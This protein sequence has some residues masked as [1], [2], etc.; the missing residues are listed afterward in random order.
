[1]TQKVSI[2]IPTLNHSEFLIRQLRYYASVES[3]HPV[4]IGD[5]SD[6]EHRRSTELAIEKLQHQITIYYHHWP[7]LNDRQTIKRLGGVAGESYCAFT[8]DDDFLIPDSL[9]KCAG[10]LEGNPEY[11]TAQGKAVLF[12]LKEPDTFGALG[13]YW[14][15]KEAME[16]TGVDRILH[17]GKNYW[18]PQF[19][20]HRQDEFLE[21]SLNYGEISNRSFGEILHCFTFIC[22]GKSKFVDC[23]YMLRQGHDSR[24]KLPDSFDWLTSPDWQP[25]FRLFMNT[26]SKALVN[27]DDIKAEEAKEAVKQAFWAYLSGGI[28][29][30]YNNKYNKHNTWNSFAGKSFRDWIKG[31]PG[32]RAAVEMARE[33]RSKTTSRTG[34]LSLPALL[35]P[36]SP[37]HKDFMP[38]YKAVVK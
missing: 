18:V 4:Y 28:T 20:V 24:F 32:T 11:R 13:T 10:F 30:A 12:L 22:K 1:M 38:V 31:V 23:L 5:G 26:I 27:V 8:G 3:P 33:L 35:N 29:R 19:S 7:E 14:S 16:N 37:Y 2:L 15:K 25:S 9:S 6:R 21:D 17:F 34:E 36:A